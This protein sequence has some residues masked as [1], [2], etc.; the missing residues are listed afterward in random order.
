MKKKQTDRHSIVMNTEEKESEEA[1]NKNQHEGAGEGRS[2]Q[3]PGV[4]SKKWK[5][6]GIQDEHRKFQEKGID[7]FLFLLHGMRKVKDMHASF[8]SSQYYGKYG[9]NWKCIGCVVT[10]FCWMSNSYVEMNIYKDDLVCCCKSVSPLYL[11]LVEKKT[12]K[13]TGLRTEDIIHC[14]DCKHHWGNVIV[15]LA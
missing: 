15:I 4:P 3:T 5:V 11:A 8:R 7:T 14:P 6:R 10:F 9:L 13:I 2:R 12:V 1:A